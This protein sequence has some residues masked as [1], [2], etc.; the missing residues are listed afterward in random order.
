MVVVSPLWLMLPLPAVTCPPLG[1]AVLLTIAA[2]TGGV[3]AMPS[4]DD[5]LN[6]SAASHAIWRAR[7]MR[8]ALPRPRE[9]SETTTND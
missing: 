8:P 1:L 3:A 7:T 9:I 2:A 5:R 6:G 4:V